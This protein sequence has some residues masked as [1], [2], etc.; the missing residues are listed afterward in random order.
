MDENL[1]QLLK[2]GPVVRS[3]TEKKKAQT[4]LVKLF[5]F[6]VAQLGQCI[7]MLCRAGLII[8]LQRVRGYRH[9]EVIFQ[10]PPVIAVRSVHPAQPQQSEVRPPPQH[11]TNRAGF[12]VVAPP[13]ARVLL[14]P[15]KLTRQVP[16]RHVSASS[17]NS[18]SSARSIMERGFC[19]QLGGVK[20]LCQ[21]G[22]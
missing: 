2:G 8:R 1:V 12:P 22:G 7:G 17:S 14:H 4:P 16:I 5:D 10:Q 20:S 18:V 3:I 6:L 13:S 15:G 21:V 9:P 11:R 19:Q